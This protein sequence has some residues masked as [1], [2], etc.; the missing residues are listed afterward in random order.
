MTRGT[1]VPALAASGFLAIL[2]AAPAPGQTADPMRHA[3]HLGAEVMPFNIAR[4][5]HVFE[6]AADGGR[7]AVISRD[8]EAG[9]IAMI[10]RHLRHEAAAFASGDYSDPAAIHGSDMPGLQTLE[11]G[12]S[13]I[14]V[15]F[16]ALPRGG[17]LRFSTRNPNL[18]AAVHEWFV[19]QAHDHEGDATTRP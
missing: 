19:A 8:G 14:R 18:V 6:A 1:K 17:A 12:A 7:M 10:R 16:E 4:S 3:G 11:K 13:G 2:Y 15:Q 5:L 9:Q